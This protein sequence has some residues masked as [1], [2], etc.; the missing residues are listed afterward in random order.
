MGFSPTPDASEQT[1]VSMQDGGQIAVFTKPDAGY[2]TLIGN[3][4]PPFPCVTDAP[5]QV[6]A[7]WHIPVDT[8]CP[9]PPTPAPGTQAWPPIAYPNWPSLRARPATH[10]SAPANPSSTLCLPSAAYVPGP[11]GVAHPAPR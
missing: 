2:W 3:G 6:L 4:G 5:A 8:S 9:A 11:G 7:Y 1:K 10:R